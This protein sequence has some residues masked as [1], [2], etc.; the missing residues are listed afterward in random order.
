[1]FK[2]FSDALAFFGHGLLVFTKHT[3]YIQNLILLSSINIRNN[4]GTNIFY[5]S[6]KSSLE[7]VRIKLKF[8]STSS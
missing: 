6:P 4:G 2:A 8:I 1:M 7:D 5:L 3:E